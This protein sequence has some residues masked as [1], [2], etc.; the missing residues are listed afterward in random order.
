MHTDPRMGYMLGG[1]AGGL[2]RMQSA[3]SGDDRYEMY[4]PLKS[5]QT[6][7]LSNCCTVSGWRQCSGAAHPADDVRNAAVLA[8]RR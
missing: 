6:L 5:R 1:H 4:W 3:A 7:Q 8:V 2:H